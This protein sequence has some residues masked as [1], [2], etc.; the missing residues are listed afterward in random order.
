VTA[1]ELQAQRLQNLQRRGSD[2]D[3]GVQRRT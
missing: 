2:K 1:L 3:A